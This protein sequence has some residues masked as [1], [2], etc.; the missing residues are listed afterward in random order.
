LQTDT[1]DSD[2]RK[3]SK[4]GEYT[5]KAIKLDDGR[6]TPLPSLHQIEYA[7]E[8]LL[9]QRTLPLPPFSAKKLNGKKLYEYA[10]A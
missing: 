7:L 10:R 4:K 6:T 3:Y 2:A 1:R 5:K 8:N 9:A